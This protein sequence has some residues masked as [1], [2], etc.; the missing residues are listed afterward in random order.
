MS[1]EG[2][3]KKCKGTRCDKS[4]EFIGVFFLLFYARNEVDNLGPSFFCAPQVL[5]TPPPSNCNTLAFLI[6]IQTFTRHTL[7]KNDREI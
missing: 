5:T 3:R 1:G 6:K 4:V 2:V 7:Y